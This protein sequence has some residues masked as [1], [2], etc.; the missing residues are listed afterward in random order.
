MRALTTLLLLAGLQIASAEIASDQYDCTHSGE[1][2]LT[3]LLHTDPDFRG[4]GAVIITDRTTYYSADWKQNGLEIRIDFGLIPV[5]DGSETVY[6]FA[7][8]IKPG[9]LTSYY[10]FTEAYT[11]T[12]RYELLCKKRPKDDAERPDREGP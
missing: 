7:L 10:D 5:K 1:P 6:Q 4:T 11:T 9:G 8:V 12:A 3:A 2:F